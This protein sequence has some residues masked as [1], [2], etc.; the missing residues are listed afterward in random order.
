MPN[1]WLT[2][3]AGNHYRSDAFTAGLQRCGFRV[4]RG[5][6]TSPLAG[7][8]LV[9]WNRYGAVDRAA[10][11]F[12]QRKLPVIV[13][14]NGYLGHELKGRRIYAL[15]RNHHNGAGTWP[16]G[17]PER[18]EKLGVELRPWRTEGETVILPQRGIGPPGVAMPIKWPREVAHLGRTRKHPGANKEALPLEIDLGRAGRVVTWGSGGA[19]KALT[20][21]IPVF[22]A[23]PQWI[24]GAAAR[25]LKDIKR[26]PLIDDAARLAMF[27]RLAWAQAELDEIAS[28]E[29]IKRLLEH[30]PC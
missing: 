20:M 21:G 8:I 23:M 18:W 14:E 7:D 26:G 2:I 27:R 22:F 11:M 28:G 17:G 13:A 24:G 9:T 16:V 30:K 6:P 29:A 19:I 1:A 15:A 25:P 12:E 10:R 3:R 4:Q 5:T